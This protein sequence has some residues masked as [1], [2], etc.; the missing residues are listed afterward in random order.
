MYPH[1]TE[2]S[3]FGFE[4]FR[5]DRRQETSEKTTFLSTRF[6]SPEHETKK[7]K[8]GMLIL[9]STRTIFTVDNPRLIWV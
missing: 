5:T 9:P 6:T 4:R 1:L 3:A 2:V 8:L 7:S